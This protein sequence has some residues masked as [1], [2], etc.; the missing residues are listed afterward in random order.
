MDQYKHPLTL[1]LYNLTSTTVMVNFELVCHTCTPSYYNLAWLW[2]ADSCCFSLQKLVSRSAYTVARVLFNGK[3]VS[4][5][6]QHAIAAVQVVGFVLLT[7]LI[8][9]YT[10]D[11]T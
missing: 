7:V 5:S 8:R 2:R 9:K 4:S 1:L 11:V 6:D 3:D 10:K